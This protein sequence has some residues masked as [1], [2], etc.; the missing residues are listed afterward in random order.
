[1]LRVHPRGRPEQARNLVTV[2]ADAS[3]LIA[4]AQ[5]AQLPLLEKLFG[6]IL[7]PPAVAREVE[8]S[9]PALVRERP[10][11]IPAAAGRDRGIGAVK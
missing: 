1:M 9:L 7:V 10:R 5:V 2:V 4:L 11:P 6:E 3:P 8:L